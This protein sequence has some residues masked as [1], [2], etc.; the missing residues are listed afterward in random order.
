MELKS[1]VE[2]EGGKRDIKQRRWARGRRK[3]RS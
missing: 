1:E 3:S 2:V